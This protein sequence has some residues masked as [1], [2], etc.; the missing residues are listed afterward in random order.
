MWG[1]GRLEGSKVQKV[2]KVR[3][4]GSLEGLMLHALRPSILHLTRI[5]VALGIGFGDGGDTEQALAFAHG[6]ILAK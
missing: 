4:F 3:K 5:G 6:D 1:V 2:R